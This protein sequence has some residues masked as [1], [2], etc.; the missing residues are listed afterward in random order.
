MKIPGFNRNNRLLKRWVVFVVLA[1]MLLG[2]GMAVASGGEG[3][4]GH[5]SKGWADTD[6][7]KVLNFAVL[8]IAL[9]LVLRKPV[10]QGLNGRIES[11]KTQLKELEEKKAEAEKQLAEYNRQLER[12]D[13]E[14]EQMVAEYIRQG[15]EAKTCIL[16]EA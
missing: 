5:A 3:H 15:E 8:A 13:K 2:A 16:K 4:E 9:F 7:Y 6:T 12:L 14:A 1:L 10:S 11:I